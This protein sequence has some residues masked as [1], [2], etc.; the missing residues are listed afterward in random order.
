MI[1]ELKKHG[2]YFLL[3]RLE[4]IWAW[5]LNFVIRVFFEIN[6]DYLKKLLGCYSYFGSI[7][8]FDL[9]AVELGADPE[10]DSVAGIGAYRNFGSEGYSALWLII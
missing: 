7:L 2:P 8:H 5:Q 10:I 9:A 3:T 4:A 6:V 1:L